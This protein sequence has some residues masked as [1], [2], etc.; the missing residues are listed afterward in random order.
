MEWKTVTNKLRDHHVI[1]VPDARPHTAGMSC[2]CQPYRDTD[3][4]DVVIHHC[5]NIGE[6]GEGLLPPDGK[7][8]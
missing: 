8:Q 5:F 1:P 6:E 4:T 2:W 7:Y 3:E